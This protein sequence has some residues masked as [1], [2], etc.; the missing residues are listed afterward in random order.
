MSALAHIGSP[1]RRMVRVAHR[2]RVRVVRFLVERDL[3]ENSFIL[4]L[5]VLIGLG[6]GLGALAFRWLIDG[7]RVLFLD[8]GVGLLGHP[9]LLPLIPAAGGALVGFIVLRYARE[10]RGHGVP[11]VMAAAAVEGGRIRPRVVIV[12]AL[13]SAICIGS[14]GSVGREGPIVQIGSAFGSSVGQLFGFSKEK[15]KVLLGCGAAAGISA[16]FNAP[17]AGGVFALEVIL[18]DFTVT[19]FSPIILSSVI[20]TAF[21]RYMIGNEPAFVIPSYNMTGA[22]ELG[23]YALLAVLAACVAVAFTRLLYVVEDAFDDLPIT[24]YAK[25]V[26]GGLLVGTVGILYPQVFGVGYDT[27]TDALLGNM[28]LTL[29]GLLLGAKFLATLSTLGSGG[30]GGIFAPSLFLGAMLGG[31]YGQIIHGIFPS[32]AAQPGAYAL[33][34]M[35]AVV[36]GT[37]HAPLTAMLI[38]FELTDD[39]HIIL[40]LM[41]A[42]VVSTL[43]AK[44]IYRES[45]YTLKLSRRGLRVAQGLDVSLL[46]SIQV[47]EVMQPNCDFVKMQTPLG[48]IVSLLQHS[49]LTDFPVV[50]DQ[51]ELKGMVSFQDIKAVMGDTEVYPLLIA[52]DTVNGDPPSVGADATLSDAMASFAG[53]DVD[54]LPVISP[55]HRLVGVLTRSS[56]MDRY[57]QELKKRA[58][59]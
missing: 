27:I 44:A 42:T 15:V 35:G 12:K 7:F 9:Y 10:A 49:E 29:L 24:D 40:P 48:D 33:V 37:T 47:E 52:A 6:G 8:K 46:E 43:V 26:I 23:A 58:Q 55:D 59:A 25:P 57:A 38:L 3:S 51:G 28:N 5:A 30:S 32:V 53:G 18:G 45:I 39:Y 11:E 2:A 13:A 20:A 4:V 56:L 19:T 54:N 22:H 41:L 1:W 21:T 34:G 17:L 36:A 31:A 14:G 16:T 50:N